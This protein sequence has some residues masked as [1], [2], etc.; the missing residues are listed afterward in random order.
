MDAKALSASEADQDLLGVGER[1][2]T[3][4]PRKGTV[5]GS[6][7]N[8]LKAVLRSPSIS[9]LKDLG[10]HGKHAPSPTVS[11]Q[12]SP[13]A[14]PSAAVDRDQSARSSRPQAIPLSHSDVLPPPAVPVAH[15]DGAEDL[16]LRLSHSG[17]DVPAPAPAPASK[18]QWRLKGMVAVI[19]HADRTPKQKMKFTFH[20]APFVDLLKGHREE[21]LLVGEAALLS[22]QEAV[23]Q[24]MKDGQEDKAK[25]RTLLLALQ[26]KGA[27]A[28]T[29]VQ[30]KPVFRKNKKQ[31]AS[32]PATSE[33][34]G[35]ATTTDDAAVASGSPTAQLIQSE[36]KLRRS[37]S[38]S[39]TTMSR[40]HAAEDNLVLEKLQLVMKWGGEPTHSARYQASD[41]GENM[42]NDLLLMNRE[43][44]E[45]VSI[46][47]SSERRVTTSA[48]IFAS[49]FLNH[50]DVDPNYISVRKD[51]LDD[52]NAAKDEMDKVKKKLKGLL[53]QGK[54]APEQFSWPR[55]G[56]PEPY[57]IVRHVVE[58]MNFHRRVMRHNFAKLRTEAQSS[59]E[60]VNRNANDAGIPD[61][62]S[63]SGGGSD[64][65]TIQA[66][67][68]AGEDAELFKERW[69]KLFDEFTDAERVDPSKISE[70]YDT[71]KF[72]A[73][74]NRQFLEW[75]FTPRDGMI[76]ADPV[77][78]ARLQRTVSSVQRDEWTHSHGNAEKTSKADGSPNA[79]NERHSKETDGGQRQHA[80]GV[81]H[82]A[83]QGHL[84][85]SL[86]R[87]T[88]PS[89]QSSLAQ[90]AQQYPGESYFN[91]FTGNTGAPVP[92]ARNDA[93]LEQLRE[94]YRLS[95][96]LFDYIGPQEYGMLDSEKLEIG[97]L[98][99]LPLLKEIV[100]DLE[101]V[102]AA[103]N[104]KS[105]IYFTKESHIY[106]LLNC[107]LGGGVPSKIARKAIP[108]L[109]YLSQICF[110]LYE[111]QNDDELSVQSQQAQTGREGDPSSSS[112][113]ASDR[114]QDSFNYSIRIAISPGCHTF[115]P[116][117]VQLD[118][119]HCI[120][121]APRRGLT[122]HGDW[123]EVIATLKNK[124]HTVKLPRSFL[125]VNLS[126]KVPGAFVAKEDDD[127]GAPQ[128]EQE[129]AVGVEA[130]PVAPAH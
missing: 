7:R 112:S 78:D 99:S 13:L 6:H 47:S 83:S 94:L 25:L 9:R 109:D 68:C 50:Q 72:D 49:A 31:E 111:S 59:L 3:P 20:S 118:S 51:L 89:R 64:L 75:V 28:G 33:Q 21:V 119:K 41:L 2:P 79:A 123:K 18:S 24:A 10:K 126:E 107:I 67:W 69:E 77:D 35:D 29:K 74:H 62:D 48:Q 15:G 53:R 95:K 97:L 60:N 110:E 122:A 117:D 105:F 45:D 11:G 104:A 90:P 32:V 106:T 98:T 55:D 114:S 14:S 116:L 27:L 66:R 82:E 30:I 103:A 102:Q 100:K 130:S 56:T 124:F 87:S 101:D 12:T 46:Y 92:K 70:L 34:S 81:G 44:L 52:S 125:A 40:I 38:I 8:A 71:M 113:S 63:T 5:P 36:K 42:R 22:V 19:R 127:K 43:A 58:L 54:Q 16:A 96:I 76:Q 108:E 128:E 121:C 61:N 120:G 85:E 91:L 4:G 37:E 86:P 17:E 57:V 26:K 80:S 23:K 93:R 65:K 88:D 73:L 129:E 1:Q 39:E 84:K 115:D